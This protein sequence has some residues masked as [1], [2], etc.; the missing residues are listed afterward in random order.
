MVRYRNGLNPVWHLRGDVDR[1]LGDIFGRTTAMPVE[2]FTQRGEF[3]PLNVWQRD[4]EVF[5][6]A[7]L[8]GVKSEDLE[9]S[10]IG[11][12]L[13]LKGHRPDLE[14]PG[15]TYH[16]RERSAGEFHRVLRLPAEINAKKVEAHLA[17]GVLLITLPKSETAKPKKITV[18]AK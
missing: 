10:V 18:Q 3:P 4:E 12:Q 7:E 9:I 17:D 5:V 8:P 2:S 6:E 15:V 14:E 13:T 1:L 11:N 16:R